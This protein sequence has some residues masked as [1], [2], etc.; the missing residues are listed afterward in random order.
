MRDTN[1]YDVLF[2]PVKIGPVTAKNRFYQVPHCNGTSDWAPDAVARMREIKAEGGWG[3]VC[4]E[5]VEVSETT[6]LHPFPSLHLWRDADIPIQAKMVE[7]VHRHGALAGAEL[8]HFGLAA[9]NRAIRNPPLGPSSHLTFESLEPF[10]CKAMDKDDIRTFREQHKAAAVRAKRAG[11]DIVYVYAAHNL[12]LASHFLSR[13]YNQRSDEYGGSLENRVRLLRELLLDT[14]EAVGDTCAVAIRFAVDEMLGADGVTFDGEGRE[15]VEMLKDLPDLWDVNIADWS[16]DSDT[17]RFAKEGFQESFTGFVKQITDKP[18]VGVGRFT[19]PDT[20]VSQIRRGVM[21]L[22]GAA[23]PSIAD[24]FLPNKIR[25]GRP[26]DIREC[27][28]CNVCVSGEMSY[29]PMRCT[30]NPTVM[31]EGR[32]GWHPEHMP[33]KGSDDAVLI[34]GAGPAGLEC[35]LSLARRGYE[36]TLAEARNDVGGRVTA[37]SALPGLAEWA[38]VRDYRVHQLKQMS[39]V[40]IYCESPMDAGQVL[41]F[42]VARVVI[43][44]GATWRRDGVGRANFWPVPGSDAASVLTPD[45]IMGGCDV[46]GPVLIYDSD[47][48][49]IGNTVAEKL[50]T[51]GYA[52]SIVTPSPE[53]A[54]Y[55]FL[56]LE[57]HKVVPHLMKLGVDIVRLKQLAAV[58]AGSVRLDCVYGGDSVTLE[59]RT[60]VMVTGRSPNDALYRDLLAR[61]DERK[62]AGVRTLDRIG[63]CLAPS[64][65]AAAVYSGHRHAREFDKAER[66]Y[67][68]Y[69][70]DMHQTG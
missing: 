26:E 4:T 35:A 31:E 39:N 43:A 32:R 3:V 28:G 15:V 66:D 20:M 24:P 34:V 64:I 29:S 10:Q 61:G 14:R 44:T 40:S 58:E 6:E 36:V 38:R 70:P 13:R 68:P 57:Q 7:A 2:E 21:D 42:G 1:R 22:I 46:Q 12:S 41:E 50:S 11:F 51:A 37:E 48:S 25:E 59:A 18:V 49:Y 27:I 47:G 16:Y 62:S 67:V 60:V 8:G 63:D 45:D 30:Q 55:L 56:T 53:I 5:I 52:V 23:R 19:S 17:S 69:L 9:G 65:I 33:A 54:G